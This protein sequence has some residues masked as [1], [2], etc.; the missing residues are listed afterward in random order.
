VCEG[1]WTLY[2]HAL[3]RFGAVPSMI[4]RDDHVP[5]LAETLAELDV[6]RG[7]AAGVRLGRAA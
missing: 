4:E 6:A 7:I 2:A 1:V 5:P 3:R